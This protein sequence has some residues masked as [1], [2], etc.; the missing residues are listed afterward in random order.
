MIEY[1]EESE[2]S[3]LGHVVFEGDGIGS[4]NYP[5]LYHEELGFS[6][7]GGVVLCWRGIELRGY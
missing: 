7:V 1:L 3:L 6:L 4:F 2:F 5:K